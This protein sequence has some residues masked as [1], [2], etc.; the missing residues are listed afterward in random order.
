MK[1]ERLT[2]IF[3]VSIIIL[4]M[5]LVFG[6][7]VENRIERA[8][9]PKPAKIINWQELYPFD[10]AARP[11]DYKAQ[12]RTIYAMYEHLK[13]ACKAYISHLLGRMTIVEAAKNYEDFIG[14]NIVPLYEYN[15][16][17][18]LIDGYLVNIFPLINVSLVPVSVI[19]FAEY[20]R[21][22]NIDFFYV[23]VPGKVC[24]YEDRNISGTL[25]FSN[26][27]VD[28]FLELLSQAGVKFYD[29]RKILHEDG[30]N[31][32]EVLY[33]TDHHWKTETGLWAAKHILEFLRDDYGWDVQPNILEPSRFEH[34][35]YPEWF[36]GSLGKKF[37]L[38]RTKPDDFTMLYPKFKTMI[39][40]EAL[41]KGLD[42][43]GDFSITYDMSQVENKDYYGK[44]PYAAYGRGDRPLAKT[45]NL[46]NHNGKRILVIH[47]S[48]ANSVVPFLSLGIEYTDEIDLR[49]FTGSLKRYIAEN[50]PDLIVVFYQTK[51]TAEEPQL[52][53]H[54]E[55]YDFR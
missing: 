40:Y 44:N 21:D 9:E 54:K 8:A 13:E 19:D 35:V 37:M 7:V 5:C 49:H 16:V 53:P 38:P 20:C 24:I 6:S 29:F 50:P 26:Q 48:F 47:D 22:N 32:H 2:A 28:K 25:D 3:F 43:T 30:M 27:N 41:D 52:S 36:L 33:R 11:E 46:M 15:G 18:K 23:N 42:L 34:V 14:W 4:C 45:H 39:H 10:E 1:P 17:T 55:F 51:S 12:R 31:H